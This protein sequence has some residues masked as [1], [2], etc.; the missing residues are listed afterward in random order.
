[1]FHELVVAAKFD[2][3]SDVYILEMQTLTAYD[4]LVIVLH[5]IVVH[6]ISFG[7]MSQ[8]VCDKFANI[9]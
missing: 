5:L 1:M 2:Y 4:A 6:K 9:V 7:K 3:I 8:K